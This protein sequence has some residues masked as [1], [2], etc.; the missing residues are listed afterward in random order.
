MLRVSEAQSLVMAKA[1]ALSAA[2][3]PISYE[4]LGQ[5][6]AE[7]VI[8]DIDMPPFDKSLMDGFAVRSA[9]LPEGKATLNI[10]EEVTAG[11]TPQRPVA[12]GQATRIMTGAPIPT[13]ADAVVM[14]ERTRLTND[15]RVQ[16]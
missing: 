3:A 14:I 6:L 11:Q 9:D 13:G 8:S 12:L 4:L 7:D 2:P 15:G 5:V 10:I 16:I 1:R